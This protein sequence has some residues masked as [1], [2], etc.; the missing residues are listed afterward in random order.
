V[1]E[2]LRRWIASEEWQQDGGK[3]IPSPVTFLR[4]RRWKDYPAAASTGGDVT[5]Y[6]EEVLHG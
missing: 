6:F 5:P 2:G 1:L 4:D 3:F